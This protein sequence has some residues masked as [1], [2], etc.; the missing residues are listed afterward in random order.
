METPALSVIIVTYNSS[1]VIIPCLQAVCRASIA[2]E[3]I[4]IDNNSADST[5]ALIEEYRRSHPDRGP[6][7][8]RNAR[9]EGYAAA[10]NTGLGRAEGAYLML[11]GPDTR[12]G[13][14]TPG[15]LIDQLQKY[16]GC[17]MIAPRLTDREGRVMPSVRKFPRPADLLLELSCLPALFPR[18]IRPAWK[19]SGFDYHRP[20]QI[21]QPEASCI[22]CRREAAEQ[23]GPMDEQFTMFFN[24]VDWCRRFRAHGW[25]IRYCPLA[26]AVHLGGHS[27]YRHRVPMIWKSHQGFYRYMQKYACS[28][29][30]RLLLSAAGAALIAGAMVRSLFHLMYAVIKRM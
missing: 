7:L 27:V 28:G 18:H 11:L 17:G 25:Q 9:N 22:L 15:I 10:V 20:A 23:A 2:A 19:N 29:P 13:R 8:I 14:D 16:P 26:S 5:P 6:V 30:Q 24:D 12:I 3:V 21:D 1:E 4:I